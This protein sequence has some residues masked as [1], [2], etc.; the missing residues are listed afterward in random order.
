MLLSLTHVSQDGVQFIFMEDALRGRRLLL[1][2]E[3]ETH[4]HTHTYERLHGLHIIVFRRL[5]RM[6]TCMC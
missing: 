2:D 5:R 3:L 4:T 1:M 6:C